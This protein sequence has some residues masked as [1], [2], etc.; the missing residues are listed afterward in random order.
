MQAHPAPRKLGTHLISKKLSIIH[1]TSRDHLIVLLKTGYQ[2]IST[3][4]HSHRMLSKEVERAWTLQT[5][6]NGY[7][8]AWWNSQWMYHRK[9][10]SLFSCGLC[11]VSA[12]VSAS[13][14]V[15]QHE[16]V[17]WRDCFSGGLD[18]VPD[19][20]HSRLEEGGWQDVAITKNII[21]I[22]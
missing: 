9:A 20:R 13:E 3:V 5:S 16:L 4:E 15:E 18:P 21:Q 22:S 1:H 10:F 7:N 19:Q 11:K 6:S 8:K 14:L 2:L 12:D 17:T